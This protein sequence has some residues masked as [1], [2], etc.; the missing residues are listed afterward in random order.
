MV[1]VRNQKRLAADILDCGENR[2]WIDQ[3]FIDEVADAVTREDVRRLISQGYIEKKQKKGTSRG[4]ARKQTTQK[5][6]GR[7]KGDGSRTGAQG[8]RQSKKEAWIQT[9]RP[10]RKELKRLRDE[11]I[12]DRSIYRHLYDEAKGGAFRSVRHL[13]NHIK[14]NGYAE[15]LQV[16]ED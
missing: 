1:D 16:G 8:A 6:K 10:L 14:E 5:E 12:I 7:R 4:R 2:V 3:D 11:E 9:I 15:D 13:R